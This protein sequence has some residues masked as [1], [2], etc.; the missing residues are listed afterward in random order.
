MRRLTKIIATLTSCAVLA[1]ATP[2]Q[3]VLHGRPHPHPAV[4]LLVLGKI[5]CTG[6][7]IAPTWVLT[8]KHC[9]KEG[10]SGIRIDRQNYHPVAAIVHPTDD[11]AVVRLDR[12]TPV[13]PVALSDSHLHPQE[14]GVTIGYGATRN[15]IP[16]AAD[17]VVQRRIFNAPAPLHTVTIIEGQAT[18]GQIYAG[19]SGGPL[20][21]AS[22]RIAAVES[23]IAHPGTVAFFTPVAEHQEWITRHAQ[24][25]A[26][27]PRD[28]AAV[29]VDAHRFPVYVPPAPP[30]IPGLEF[31]QAWIPQQAFELDTILGGL[32]S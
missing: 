13:T 12:P 14:K 1:T 31:L 30:V 24:L 22:G 29:A 28:Q 19:D 23:A 3:A 10:P 27:P 6:T 2:A 18:G 15:A 32:S 7:V 8:A 4:A 26:V 9:V 5:Q 25:P 17:I 11:I 20:L 16:T 21:D